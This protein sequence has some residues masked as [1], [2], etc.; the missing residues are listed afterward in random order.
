MSSLD[1]L[2]IHA[3]CLPAHRQNAIHW[4]IKKI[5][6]HAEATASTRLP[7][8]SKVFLRRCTKPPIPVLVAS[9]S[10]QSP[11]SSRHLELQKR[12]CE[13]NWTFAVRCNLETFWNQNS[14][15]CSTRRQ[16][17]RK[18]ARLRAASKVLA[19]R[20]PPPP[21][22]ALQESAQSSGGNGVIRRP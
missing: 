16:D 12:F 18:D 8:T 11:I 2:V 17:E 5:E 7:Q 19:L 13:S 22:A 9:T 14:R 20:L 15:R 1:L 10:L 4:P 21:E 3:D 6:F